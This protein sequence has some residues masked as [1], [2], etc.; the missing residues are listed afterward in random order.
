MEKKVK[1]SDGA[2]IGFDE[3]GNITTYNVMY[4]KRVKFGFDDIKDLEKI[5]KEFKT[6]DNPKQ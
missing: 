6:F 2:T 1:L 3:N 5:L 4:G